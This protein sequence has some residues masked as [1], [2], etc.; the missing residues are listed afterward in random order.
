MRELEPT[1][2]VPNSKRLLIGRN[3]AIAVLSGFQAAP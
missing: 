3:Q 2:I 1:A